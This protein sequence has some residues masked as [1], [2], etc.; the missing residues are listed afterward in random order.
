MNMQL[1]C[2]KPIALCDVRAMRSNYISAALHANCVKQQ[3]RNSEATIRALDV[4]V[5]HYD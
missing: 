1:S 4:Y 5:M 2:R 3:R